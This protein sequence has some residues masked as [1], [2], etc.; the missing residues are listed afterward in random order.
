MKVILV[1]SECVPYC[2]TGGLAD[3]T[4]ALYDELKKQ[5]IDVSLMLPYYKGVPARGIAS[6]ELEFDVTLSGKHYTARVFRSNDAYFIYNETL[7][8]RDGL[9]GYN[10]DYEDNDLRFAFF[11]KAVLIALKK[12]GL[13]PHILHLH[14]WQAA[15][16]AVFLKNSFKGDEFL[17][18]IKTVLTI[19]NLGYQGIFDKRALRYLELDEKKFTPEYVEFYGK[20]NYLKGGILFSD[21]ITT[22]SENYAREI[23]TEQ[24]GAGLHGVLLKRRDVLYGIVNGIDYEVWSPETDPYIY[25][26]YSE[27]NLR[28]KGLCKLSLIK[29]LGIRHKRQRPLVSFVGRLTGQKGIELLEENLSFII[30]QGCSMVILGEGEP[31]IERG[32]NK[33]LRKFNGQLALRI[34]FNEPLAHMVYAGSDIILMPSRYEPCGLVQLIALRYGTIP[35]ARKTGGLADTIKDYD[36]ASDQ[37]TGFVFDDYNGSAFREAIKRALVVF[38]L[39]AR[40]RRIITSAMRERFSW[41]DSA[42]RYIQLY[43]GAIRN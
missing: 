19:H 3:V 34:G 12:L 7:F 21:L 2:K 30:E 4:R 18:D 9:Y 27:K 33:R 35:V 41:K 6:T 39:K 38:Y 20:V 42:L 31:A 16:I 26:N 14:D 13:R 25:T 37:G 17:K 10:G 32:L 36:P 24:Y 40:W 29:E 23:L 28:G 22:V 15:P 5:G 8:Y 11:S 43:E 1:A